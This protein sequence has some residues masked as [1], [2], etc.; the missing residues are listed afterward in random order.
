ME[1]IVTNE[2]RK[3]QTTYSQP[4]NGTISGFLVRFLR[5]IQKEFEKANKPK[6][7]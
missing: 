3:R 5:N 6:P 7:K 1:E 2:Q 4:A